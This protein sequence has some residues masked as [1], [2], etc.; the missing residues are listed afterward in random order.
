MALKGTYQ[1]GHQQTRRALQ[2]LPR[3]T[4]AVCRSFTAPSQLCFIGSLQQHAFRSDVHPLAG[5][6]KRK[7]VHAS[8][9]LAIDFRCSVGKET[10]QGSWVNL[11]AAG[12]MQEG[13]I[14][15]SE[16]S[17]QVSRAP[18]TKILSCGHSPL[19]QLSVQFVADAWTHR[20]RL[21]VRSS[22]AQTWHMQQ[23]TPI[24]CD[25]GTATPFRK[26]ALEGQRILLEFPGRAA[27][28]LLVPHHEDCISTSPRPFTTGTMATTALG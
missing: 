3:S 9:T 2:C 5:L 1:V 10:C 27:L 6:M 23:T 17:G 18:G 19:L 21:Q 24:H 8:T 11:S 12:L 15:L 26:D 13:C 4:A 22:F 28:S 20:P 7:W 25:E 16:G 14:A